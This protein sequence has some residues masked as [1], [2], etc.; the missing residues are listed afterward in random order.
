MLFRSVMFAK[1]N[2]LTTLDVSNWDTHN[3]TDMAGMFEDCNLLTSLDVSNFDTSNVTNMT[4]MINECYDLTVL[5]ISNWHLNSEVDVTDM[6]IETNALTNVIMNNS[7]SDSVNKIISEL[8]TK[9]TD[10]IGTL[11]VG[12]IDDISQVDTATAQSK[13]WNISTLKQYKI[14]LIT[15]NNEKVKKIHNQNKKLKISIYKY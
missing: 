2:K 11:Y 13:Y 7:D 12:G 6:F 15:V 5:N 10:S 4:Q 9:T 1:C 14:H 8:P 3:V